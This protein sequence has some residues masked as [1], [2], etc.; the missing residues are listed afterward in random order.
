MEI[1]YRLEP[2]RESRRPASADEARRVLQEGNERFANLRYRGGDGDA[3]EVILLDPRAV[4]L[5]DVEGEPP[6]QTP[7]A[8]VLGCADARVPVDLVFGQAVND[9]FV[10]RVAGNVLAAECLGSIEFATSQLE[11]VRLTIVL[12]HSGCGAVTAAVDAFSSPE[13]YLAVAVSH[14][15]RAIIDRLWPSVRLASLALSEADEDVDKRPH[16]RQ[17]LIET[18]VIVN[19]A[20][21]AMTLKREIG[22]EVA[23]GIYDLLTGRVRVPGPDADEELGLS[24]PPGDP[25]ELRSV[26]TAA[27]ASPFVRAILDAGPR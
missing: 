16:Y 27:A 4:G 1:V 3:R 12:G 8:A 23:F 2:E 10:V 25:E 24:V 26:A 19:A 17:A 20:L 5:S 7:F 22:C 18:S 21:T 6:E 9:L 15:L 11:S 14:G 13:R